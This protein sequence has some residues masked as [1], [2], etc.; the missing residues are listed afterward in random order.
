MEINGLD[1]Q[2]GGWLT[3]NCGKFPS[4]KNCQLV[5]MAP[6][7]Q[8]ADLLDAAVAHAVSSHGHQNTPELRGEL[9]TFL[10]RVQ[11]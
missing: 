5:L 6:E 3:A 11:V 10:E 4:E 8:R 7:S 2:S 1:I 9:D